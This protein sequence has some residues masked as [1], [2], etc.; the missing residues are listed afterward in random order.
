MAKEKSSR[1][2]LPEQLPEWKV[3]NMREKY[4]GLRHF[5]ADDPTSPLSTRLQTVPDCPYPTPDAQA[6]GLVFAYNPSS[7]IVAV[8]YLSSNPKSTEIVRAMT[9]K[10]GFGNWGHTEIKLK[11][12][13]IVQ[14]KVRN[15]SR[16]DW[17]GALDSAHPW[18]G[19]PP[20]W[21]TW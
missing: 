19:A 4:W 5:Q 21:P 20:P 10:R 17:N 13:G 1:R 7:Q 3:V 11:K 15:R 2:A 12:H 18:L 8:H 14:M 9:V 16:E 6:I